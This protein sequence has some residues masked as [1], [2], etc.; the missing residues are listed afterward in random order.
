[1]N[2]R[3]STPALGLTLLAL[4]VLGASPRPDPEALLREAAAAYERRDYA[5]AVSL[6]EQAEVRTT[7]PGLVAFNLAA[8]KYCLALAAEG[9][10]PQALQEAERLYRCC[11]A[12]D[13]P[14]WTRALYGLGNCLL[15]KAPDAKAANLK[16]AIDCYERCLRDPK[17]DAGLAAHARYNL[18]KARLLLAQ[19]QPPAGGSPEE[20]Q[21]GD[22]GDT[23][24]RPPERQPLHD[25]GG[26][27]GAEGR[28]DPNGGATPAQA[29]PGQTPLRADEPPPPGAGNLEPVPDRSEPTP[30]SPHDAAEHLKRATRRILEERQAHRQ[31]RARPPA[32]GVRD[33]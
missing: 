12:P 28:A 20:K 29:E 1:M 22:D 31:G 4:A 6:Y 14:R 25:P 24:P 3:H 9:G 17:V 11:L 7:D 10:S 26:D 21:G 13:D 30:L 27:P 19:F 5:A 33:W 32:P 18:Q 23:N 2:L 8:A 15:Q 16:A